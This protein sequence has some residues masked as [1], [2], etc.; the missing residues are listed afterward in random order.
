MD[1]MHGTA[2]V[3][4]D[5]TFTYI[6]RTKTIMVRIRFEF[7]LP[8]HTVRLMKWLFL[9]LIHMIVNDQ[10]YLFVVPTQCKSCIVCVLPEEHKRSTCRKS[11]RL[12]R[13]RIRTFVLP[14]ITSKRSLIPWQI[15]NQLKKNTRFT[16]IETNVI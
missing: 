14:N 15:D 3:L 12:V 5:R 6:G 1:A 9:S 13:R 11:S 16:K 2:D 4:S 10:E 7:V 8:I